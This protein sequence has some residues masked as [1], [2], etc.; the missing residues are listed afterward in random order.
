M[1]LQCH[2][3]TSH[4]KQ[5][6]RRQ[7]H[8]KLLIEFYISDIIILRC[9]VRSPRQLLTPLG[10]FGGPFHVTTQVYNCIMP[11]VV[12][13][14]LALGNDNVAMLRVK[15]FRKMC[16]NKA[17]AL[18]KTDIIPKKQHK[19]LYVLWVYCAWRIGLAYVKP[20]VFIERLEFYWL[21]KSIRM[22][23]VL[24]Y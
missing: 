23:K 10:L 8:R 7:I 17:Y 9:Y 1:T 19:Y 3:M 22:D 4:W 15:Q 18:I 20:S 24:P 11:W 14:S 13:D 5:L 12:Q 21:L 16:V 2:M 6:K